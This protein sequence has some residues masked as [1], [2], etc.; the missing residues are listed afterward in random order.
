MYTHSRAK[1]CHDGIPHHAYNCAHIIGSGGYMVYVVPV[2]VHDMYTAPR[3]THTLLN[4][5]AVGSSRL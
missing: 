3:T 4:L 1:Q 5:N 2:H